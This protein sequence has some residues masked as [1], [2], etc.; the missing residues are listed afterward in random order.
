MRIP[1][2]LSIPVIAALLTMPAMAQETE[3]END[4]PVSAEATTAITPGKSSDMEAAAAAVPAYGAPPTTN[5][6]YSDGA[7][8][9]PSAQA[10]DLGMASPGQKMM[11]GG[12]GGKGR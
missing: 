4:V 8:A 11:L 3:I 6:I 1:Y 2:L 5:P 7:L 9:A 10:E 12:G